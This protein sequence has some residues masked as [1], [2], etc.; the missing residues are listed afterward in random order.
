MRPAEIARHEAQLAALARDLEVLGLTAEV[1]I[2]SG[3][4]GR[5]VV[6]P[7][8]PLRAITSYRRWRQT[9]MHMVRVGSEVLHLTTDDL[10]SVVIAAA[11]LAVNGRSTLGAASAG[12]YC[13]PST[14]PVLLRHRTKPGLWWYS[15]AG[16]MADLGA[17]GC[18]Y[19][20][21]EERA[22]RASGMMGAQ[23]RRIARVIGGSTVIGATDRCDA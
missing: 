4:L 16:V 2:Y 13:L 3:R 21:V 5:W 9:G 23:D 8:E 20:E 14:R 18:R 6:M 17:L 12:E 22:S 7:G 19:H 11:D 10:E 15:G 1:E